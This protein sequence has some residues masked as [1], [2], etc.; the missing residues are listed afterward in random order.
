VTK[1]RLRTPLDTAI[2]PQC[3]R[4]K[5]GVPYYADRWMAYGS[6]TKKGLRIF[7]TY[8][9]PVLRNPYI[10]PESPGNIFRACDRFERVWTAVRIARECGWILPLRAN[11]PPG[12]VA[13]YLLEEGQEDT[14]LYRLLMWFH[15]LNK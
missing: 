14:N 6:V 11:T 9:W 10:E 2:I 1:T 5:L 13:D 7:G 12:V 8:S 15:G 4:H 3:L